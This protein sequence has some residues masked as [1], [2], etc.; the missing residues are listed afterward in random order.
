M[1]V[2]RELDGGSELADPADRAVIE[3]R[4]LRMRYG[5]V[6]VLDVVDVPDAD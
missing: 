1:K 3:V 5:P 2:M 4:D 6:E